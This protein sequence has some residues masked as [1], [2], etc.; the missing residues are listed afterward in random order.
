ME[1]TESQAEPTSGSISIPVMSS[2]LA[3]ASLEVITNPS[4][5]MLFVEPTNPTFLVAN[6]LSL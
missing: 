2:T 3:T 6:M 5:P 1:Q 4:S